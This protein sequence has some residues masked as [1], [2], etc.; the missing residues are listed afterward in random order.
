MPPA[1]RSPGRNVHLCKA[2][3]PDEVVGGLILNNG[4]TNA[5]LY[6][7]AEIILRFETRWHLLN[8]HNTLLPNDS[9]PLQP[10]KYL[11]TGALHVYTDGN[12]FHAS[13][14]SVVNRLLYHH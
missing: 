4:I 14:S 1:I 5:N 3:N 7:M 6:K 13:I 9:T 10:G 8:E 12:P 11:V 2:S